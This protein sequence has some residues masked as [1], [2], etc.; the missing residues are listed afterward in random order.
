MELPSV[1]LS[2][3]LDASEMVKLSVDAVPPG[4]VDGVAVNDE[5]PRAGVT[6]TLAE[7][8]AGQPEAFVTVTESWTGPVGPAE[9]VMAFVPLPP[10]IVPFVMVHA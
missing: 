8:G 3:Q 7:P 10:V 5:I 9:K 1:P 4:I 6:V 2:V